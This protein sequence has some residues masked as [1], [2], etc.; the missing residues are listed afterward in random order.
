MALNLKKGLTMNLLEDDDGILANAT[1][2]QIEIDLLRETSYLFDV[3]RNASLSSQNRDLL[4]ETSHLFDVSRNASLSSQPDTCFSEYL[5]KPFLYDKFDHTEANT[6]KPASRSVFLQDL[7]Q[8]QSSI[9]S[10]PVLPK[11][12]KL[13]SSSSE[14]HTFEICGGKKGSV[15]NKDSSK[16]KCFTKSRPEDEDKSLVESKPIERVPSELTL[17]IDNL[18][19]NQEDSGSE[20]NKSITKKNKVRPKRDR[21]ENS[22]RRTLSGYDIYFKQE[23]ERLMKQKKEKNNASNDGSITYVDLAKTIASN[24]KNATEVEKARYQQ[25]AEASSNS[26]KKKKEEQVPVPDEEKSLNTV[27]SEV[28]AEFTVTFDKP[29]SQKHD[30]SDHLRQRNLSFYDSAHIIT[31]KPHTTKTYNSMLPEDRFPQDRS[32]R[33]SSYSPHIFMNHPGVVTSFGGEPTLFHKMQEFRWQNPGFSFP[34]PNEKH[35]DIMPSHT[36]LGQYKPQGSMWESEKVSAVKDPGGKSIENSSI[37][38]QNQT[39]EFNDIEISSKKRRGRPK[40]DPTEGWPKRPLSA[41]NI[42]FKHERQKLLDS[43]GPQASDDV[44]KVDEVKG[45]GSRKSRSKKHGIISFSDL[46]KTIGATWKNMSEKE[47]DPY[48]T[49]AES[50]MTTYRK[51]MEIFLS[52]RKKDKGEAAGNASPSQSGT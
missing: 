36:A 31:Q 8:V 4:R 33:D 27:E 17:V 11:R 46:A 38:K 23:R 39:E 41:Y 14:R 15:K 24:W 18:E 5:H 21:T 2:R 28:P 35:V 45:S 10:P 37:K 49:L 20:S 7:P 43:R 50:Y 47:K 51:E 29:H 16:S 42:F 26:S 32:Q 9:F 12:P 1:S 40:R 13:L 19:I 34:K 44:P 48:K 30:H 22:H 3:S 52:K 25:L 6:W